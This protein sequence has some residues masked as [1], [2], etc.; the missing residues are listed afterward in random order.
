VTDSVAFDINASGQ[1]VGRYTV[2]DAQDPQM[3]LKTRAF[4]ASPIAMLLQRL[5]DQVVGVGPGKSLA[6]KVMNA[7]ASYAAQDVGRTCSI[8][9]ALSK[10]L[11]KHARKK[12]DGALAGELQDEV[13]AIRSA[14]VCQ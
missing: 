4:V 9:G 7:Q 10:E 5:M 14:M 8:L 11:S 2:S 12:V 1:V 3:P 13:T 6:G